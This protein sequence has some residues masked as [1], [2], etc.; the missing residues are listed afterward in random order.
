MSRKPP[1]WI[2]LS[3]LGL[4]GTLL[5]VR[6]FPL[7]FPLLAVDIQMDRDG[8]LQE[9]L[10]LADRFGW[11]PAEPRQAASFGHLNPAFQTYMELEGGG[12]EDLNRLVREG[13]VTLYAWRVRHFA[14]GVVE[15]GEVRFAP[16]GAPLGFSLI[17]S[18]DAPGNNLEEDPARELAMETAVREWALDR[19]LW[20]LLESSQTERPGGR[21][22]HTFVYE[23][24]DLGLGEASLRLRLRVAG[25]DL[26]EVTP[27]VHVPEGFQRRF[28]ATRDANAS[29]S[30]AGTIVFLLLF[31]LLGGG[32]GTVLLI[33]ERWIEWKKP[34]MWGGIVAGL[35]ALNSVNSLPLAWM[36]YD[37]ALPAGIF[38]ATLLLAAL[39]IFAA[40]TAF[41]AFVFMAGE[42]LLRK[43][44]PDQIQQWKLW[45]PG[46]ANSTPV[47]GRTAAPYLV[48]GL[49]LG[50]VV[51]FYLTMTRLAG[52]WSPASN[53]VEP[54]L[55]ATYLPWLT[56]VST[57]LFAAFSEESIFRAI[58]IGAAAILGRRYGR[59]GVWIWTAIVLQAL[60]FGASHAD[61]PQHP[62]Y[63]RVVEIFPVFLAWGV[64]VLYFGLAPAIIGHF[65]Y[66]LSLFS[67]P[68]FVADTPGI[69]VDRVMVIIAGAVPLAV[70]L[71]ARWRQGGVATVPQEALNRSWRPPPT[72]P[73]GLS[74]AGEVEEATADTPATASPTERPFL[75]PRG[76]LLVACAALVGL[77]LWGAGKAGPEPP[78][79]KV[80][81]A[82]AEATGREALQARGVALDTGW[83]PLFTLASSQGEGHQFVWQKGSDE[84]YGQLVGRFLDP[85]HWRVRFVR[86][87]VAPEERA[88]T[89]TVRLDPS[90]EIMEVA[91]TLPE[92]RPAES[93]SEDEARSLA[94][95]ALVERLGTDPGQVREIS[96][97]ERARPART[98]WTFVFMAREGYPLTQG[99]GRLEVRITGEEVTG[100][101]RFVHLPEEW[102]RERRSEASRRVL[103]SMA[104]LGPLFLLSLV[105]IIFAVIRWAQGALNTAP[106]RPLAMGMAG[107]LLVTG[108]NGWPQSIGGFTT[109]ESFANQLIV[110]ILGLALGL[111][112]L[113][114]AVGLMGALAHSW[115]KDRGHSVSRG[116]WVGLA[117]GFAL[118][119]VLRVLTRLP[120]SGPPSWPDYGA[121]VSY[122]PWASASLGPISEFLGMTVAALLLLAA[123]TRLKGTRQ[124]WLAWVLPAFAGLALAPNS[125]ET[126]WLAWLAVGAAVAAG[127]VWTRWVCHRLGW[128]L[129]PGMAAGLLLLGQVDILL[130]RPYPGSAPGAILAMGLVL[131]AAG[132]WARVL[133]RP[134]SGPL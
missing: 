10:A 50:Y 62:A 28:L 128:A 31:V 116:L 59:P 96:A 6:L 48:V 87:D 80:D 56:A 120:S 73:P 130:A 17:L 36:A 97:T 42:S 70:V 89:Y 46:V 119:G 19:S 127:I 20:E 125:P 109:Q 85:P 52:W 32:L 2:L 14:E 122:L 132:L 5:A 78:Q 60:V 51:V 111:L 29:I 64:V 115:L 105:A 118:S 37:T 44:L 1:F 3:I 74:P 110:T 88:E 43:G 95:Q 21:I 121:A 61:Y 38:I 107:S 71:V 26:V 101:R 92:G 117:L 131:A 16:S 47:L 77:V 123:M 40:G 112:F 133:A 57:S 11:A 76:K 8:A 49:E 84:E 103:A 22:D 9:A 30:L 113:S 102:E 94:L 35:M 72:K 108:L 79:M 63:A 134:G 39:G 91:R 93:L 106:I 68:L 15:E 126:P 129:L 98:D 24:P 33:R 104:V 54:D 124:G 23:R 53:L 65:V 41:L 75:S 67:L 81:L 114:M 86:F 13:V 90:G 100:Y 58:P 18:E 99:E 12:L 83:R 7:A 82:G 55:L 45:S 69:W 27:F 25:D 66:N 4:V 34:L